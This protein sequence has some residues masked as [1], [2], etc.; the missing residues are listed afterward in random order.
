MVY[1]NFIFTCLGFF[2]NMGWLQH[3]QR[4][5][6][7][8]FS[9]YSFAHQVSPSF[10]RDARQRYASGSPKVAKIEKSPQSTVAT[11]LLTELRPKKDSTEPKSIRPEHNLNKQ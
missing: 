10:V 2:G 1:F 9:Q 8:Q 7:P 11:K 5:I 6:R 3:S 4:Q